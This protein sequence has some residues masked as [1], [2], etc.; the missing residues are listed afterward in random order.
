MKILLSF[1]SH[2]S[3]SKPVW[4]SLF[5]RTQR[6]IFWRMWETEQ[7]WA[8][9]TSIV[10]FFLLLWKSMVP[11]NTLVTNF[12]QISPLCSNIFT[13][14]LSCIEKYFILNSNSDDYY[15]YWKYFYIFMSDGSQI[16]FLFF[17]MWVCSRGGASLW[18]VPPKPH[19]PSVC[20]LCVCETAAA[21]SE[22]L[23]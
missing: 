11:Q 21:V 12:L 16:F 1:T 5:C 6:K 20:F 14:I 22:L 10:F 13:F 19:N 15:Y 3:S 18:H 7:F 23:N 4:M 8:P 17:L 9:L 2:S